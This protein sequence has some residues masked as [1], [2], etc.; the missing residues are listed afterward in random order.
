MCSPWYFGGVAAMV[1]VPSFL[2]SLQPRALAALSA[3]VILFALHGCSPEA[4]GQASARQ[5]KSQRPPHLVE[6]ASAHE[7]RLRYTAERQGSLRAL[8]QVKVFNQEEGRIEAVLARQG[9]SV[10]AGT[11]L[12]RLDDRLLR[13][14]LDKAGA[15]LRQAELD[16]QRLGGLMAK[17][18]IA[19]EQLNRAMTALEVARAEERLLKARL[20]YMTIRAP[21]DG[22]LAERLIEPGDVA[23]KHTHLLTLIDPSS[24]VTEVQ[25]SEL[26]LPGL[27]VGDAAQVRID[28]FGPAVFSG[29]V[30]RLYPTIDPVTR[31][32]RIEIAL[33]P[34]PPGAAPGQFCRV[35][36]LTAARPH[37]VIPLAALQRDVDGEYVFLL[38]E[39]QKVHRTSVQSGLRF[40][41]LVEIRSGLAAGQQVV[42]RG[43]LGL[44]N[45]QV[46]QPVERGKEAKGNA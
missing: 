27:E 17:K 23:P 16:A 35:S 21:F 26:I 4:G 30:L 31:Q 13:A 10:R 32:G 7:Q 20:G 15:T 41:D 37:L 34:V 42:V 46:V 8:R 43:F 36:L 28:A 3:G 9:D 44:S 39:G 29:R 38:G 1:A 2:S 40:A 45:G 11:V 19:E 6:L 18:L 22:K 5:A 33:D 25:V 24:L 12:V 14:E